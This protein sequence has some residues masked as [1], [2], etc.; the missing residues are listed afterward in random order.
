MTQEPRPCL[1]CYRVTLPLCLRRPSDV[2]DNLRQMTA[3]AVPMD[4]EWLWSRSP[5][6]GG[7]GA[8]RSPFDDE[9]SQDEA[10]LDAL[11]ELI[12]AGDDGAFQEL[13]MRLQHEVRAYLAWRAVSLDLVEEV[14]QDTFIAVFEH[15]DG[16]DGV[17]RLRPWVFGIA[18]HRMLRALRDR[19]R[20]EGRQVRLPDGLASGDE[21]PPPVDDFAEGALVRLR[22]C[23]GR[24]S[25]VH[26]DLLDLHHIQGL[27][28]QE[29]AQRFDLS[30]DAVASRLYRCRR[31]LRRCL[32]RGAGER[33]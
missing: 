6:M 12:R 15:L 17:G 20:R 9:T 3:V 11:V 32:D 1:G 14:V 24:L 33:S 22:R 5:E 23:L 7:Y 16:Y 29:L 25:Q 13:V 27:D 30:V 8:M 4:G 2:G 21:A 31:S 28:L 19:R 18:R 26:Q 10:A